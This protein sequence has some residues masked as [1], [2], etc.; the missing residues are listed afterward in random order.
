MNGLILYILTQKYEIFFEA[1]YS[2]TIAIYIVGE[3][4]WSNFGVIMFSIWLILRQL[5]LFFKFSKKAY[6]PFRKPCRALF[7]KTKNTQCEK[8]Y[9]ITSNFPD[10]FTIVGFKDDYMKTFNFHWSNLSKSLKNTQI[11]NFDSHAWDNFRDP[12]LEKTTLAIFWLPLLLLTPT[13]Y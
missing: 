7:N 13:P 1:F 3:I 5:W 6:R 12:T 10:I 8:L 9:L 11:H 4:I 2:K